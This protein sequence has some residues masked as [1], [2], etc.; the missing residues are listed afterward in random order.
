MISG[1]FS[2][3]FFHKYLLLLLVYYSIGNCWIKEVEIS[4][5]DRAA[6]DASVHEAIETANVLLQAPELDRHIA[7]ITAHVT[8]TLPGTVPP[9]R[10]KI[11]NSSEINAFS[12]SDGT[13]YMS[14][15]IFGLIDNDAQ[16]AM[17]LAHEISHVNL[18][19]HRLFRYELHKRTAQN[20]FSTDNTSFNL[21]TALSGFSIAQER[22]ADS[23]AL[24]ILI[25]RG[26]NGW[27]GKN[28]LHT[29]YTWLKYKEKNY[30]ST[31]ATHPQLSERYNTAKNRLITINFDTT[32]GIIGDSSYQAAI[33]RYQYKIIDLLRESNCVNELYAMTKRKIRKNKNIPDW[34][35]LRGSLMERFHPIDSFTIAQTEL[36]TALKLDPSFTIG[37]RDLGWLF[38]KNRQYDSA[39][40]YLSQYL[41]HNPHARDSSLVLFYLESISE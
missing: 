13:I 11:I 29:M 38:L 6:I 33:S 32:S 5:Q 35:Y 41:V 26:Y 15:G 2:K 16:L 10:I 37:L 14:L 22:A 7:A 23:V 12:L 27:S 31:N 9:Y 1:L 17:L 36:S 18:D 34:H 4:R 21:R 25:S 30:D 40:T 24:S 20:R 3:L 8:G 19:H 39:R 28:L